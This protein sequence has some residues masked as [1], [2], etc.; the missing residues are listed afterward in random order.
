MTVMASA[1]VT[2]R[3]GGRGG[4]GCPRSAPSDSE[5]GDAA[6]LQGR[7]RLIEGEQRLV[8]VGHGLGGDVGPVFGGSG[9]VEGEHGGQVG[10]GGVSGCERGA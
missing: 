2:G 5:R 9:G 4:V 6:L 1:P 8:V 7:Q 3:S 10:G